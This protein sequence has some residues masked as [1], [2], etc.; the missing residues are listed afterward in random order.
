MLEAGSLV[1]WTRVWVS[2]LVAIAT[3]AAGPWIGWWPT[4]FGALTAIQVGTL[5][6]RT[7][8]VRAA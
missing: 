8:E 4:L 2:L 3:A 5:E 6:R 1:R 7:R